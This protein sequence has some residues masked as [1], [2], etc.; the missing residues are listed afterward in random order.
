MGFLRF[1]AV[2][3]V[4]RAHNPVNVKADHK[5]DHFG[6]GG[7]GSPRSGLAPGWSWQTRGRNKVAHL[8]LRAV[9]NV[10]PVLTGFG[11]CGS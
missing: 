5:Y 6:T 9:R 3:V 10:N 1:E 4:V 8:G 7:A 11:R 2:K